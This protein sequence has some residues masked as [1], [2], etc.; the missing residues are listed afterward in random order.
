MIQK[1]LLLQI[2][3]LY[4]FTSAIKGQRVD[5]YHKDSEGFGYLVAATSDYAI[6]WAEGAYKI[7]RDAP[8]PSSLSEKVSL[9]AAGNEYEPFQIVINP[10]NRIED[11]R[12]STSD[13]TGENGIIQADNITL[14]K[15]EYVNVTKPT[16]SYGYAAW[17]PDPLPPV[18]GPV[19]AYGEENSVFWLTAYIP[20]GTY[21]GCYK[22]N[23]TISTAGWNETI[24][25]ELNV[26][27]FD[28]PVSPSIR[29]GFGLSVDKIIDYHNLSTKDQILKTFDLYMQAF[30]DY[31]ISPYSFYALHPIKE[32]ISGICWDG[33][34]Y[35]SNIKFAGN[36]SLRIEDDDPVSAIHANY[37]KK[38]E[39]SG[40]KSY[41]LKW[42]VRAK[43]IDQKYCIEAVSYNAENE[44]IIFDNK[45]DDFTCDTVWEKGRF[46]LGKFGNDVMKISLRLYPSFRTATG[47][48]TGTVW[49]DNLVL[50]EDG[51]VT[52][53]ISQ[54]N[55]E[56]SVDEIE[57]NLDFTD[58]DYAASR[59]IDQF[60]FNAFRLD[61]K[62]MGG[63]TYY[64]RTEG[65]FA[66]FAQGGAE[67]DKLMSQYLSQIENHLKEKNWLGKE[68]I[69][70]FD[71]PG[72]SDY[73]FVREGMEQI[74]RSAPQ[75]TTF[76]TENDPGPGIMD[77]TDITCTIWHRIDPKKAAKIVEGGQEYWS[78]LCT[79]PKAPWVSE[80][81]DHDA[82]NLRIWL[83]M[84]YAYRLNGILI[85][86]SNYWTSRAASPPGYLQN[87]W[88]EPASFVQGYGWPLGKQTVWG[89][90]DGRF[91]YPPNRDPNT[92]K[93]TYIEGPV[94]SI[95][96]EF[97]R[98][99]IEDFEY[100]RILED[101]VTQIDGTKDHNKIL[102]QTRDLLEI[103]KDIFTDGKTYTKDPGRLYEYRRKLA[104]A[105][106][107]LN[108]IIK[109]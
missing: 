25:I 27:D 47:E 9:W 50:Y 82:I 1:Y 104:K 94:P 105:I 76:L 48:N 44:V 28:L 87:P 72:Q 43:D 60:G 10:V 84:S 88:D 58:F 77:V 42:N 85:W 69:Y 106:T 31:K 37:L 67:Y 83:W 97:L 45:L 16:D 103:P 41:S 14:R 107:E 91:W 63:G 51:K 81:I 61:L 90:G 59:Y 49:F 23:I 19:T 57:I 89:N 53:K 71:E 70:W 34:F 38:I 4:I 95:R 18:D 80:F 66:G 15:V 56:V 54:G 33:G 6:W 13:L 35:D 5:P 78:Y 108:N 55:F 8:Q 96:I 64:S 22:G 3:I 32:D 109:K 100:F 36:Y 7:M 92:D 39:I 30:R 52:D 75:I 73:P 11:V 68:Y 12:I 65:R 21:P 29:S 74:K 98:Q 26:W 24:P 46:N 101:L 93:T 102:K 79:A 40:D 17:W 20:A 99:G 62:G 2:L 86:S